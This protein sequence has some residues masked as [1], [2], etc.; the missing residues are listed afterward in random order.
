MTEFMWVRRGFCQFICL[1]AA[2]KTAPAGKIVNS[3]E[4]LIDSIGHLIFEFFLV[5][6]T[7]VYCLLVCLP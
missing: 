6:A 5:S 1:Y 7:I 3:G 2:Q 4:P